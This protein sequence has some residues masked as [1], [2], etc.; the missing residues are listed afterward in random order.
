MAILKAP[1]KLFSAILFIISAG[2]YAQITLPTKNTQAILYLAEGKNQPLIVGLGGSEG[3][4][5]WA[6]SHWKETRDR[7]IRKGYAFLAIGYF[8]TEGT[9]PM[10]DR[11]AIEDIHNAIAEAVKNKSIDKNKVAIVG[12]SRG[13]DLALL[14]AS[15]YKDIKCV[16]G[17]VAS[18]AVFPGNTDH[19]SASSWTFEGKELAYV[20]VNEEAVP[21]LMKRDLRGAFETMLKDTA[22]EEKAVI[23]AESINGPVLLISATKDEICPST[24]MADKIMARLKDKNFKFYSN[25][26]AI[27]GTH[28]EPLKHF[29]AVFAFLDKYFPAK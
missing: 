15:Y 5:A 24:P 3:G 25:H 26:I 10:L 12:G 13:A 8:G 16:V 27:D 28:A 20:P 4:N 11:I 22:A 9:P 7:F 1:I 17:L 29:D 14:T 2:S 23:K 6:S 19:L 18:H 21:F